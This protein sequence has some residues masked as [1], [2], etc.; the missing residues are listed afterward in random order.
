MPVSSTP[1][2][3]PGGKTI[4]TNFVKLVFARNRLCDGDYAEPFCG[5]AGVAIN[6][7]RQEY[8][9]EAYLNDLSYPIY[10]FWR[11]VLKHTDSLCDRLENTPINV[12]EWYRQRAVFSRGRRAKLADLGFATLFLNRVNRSGILGAGLIGGISQEG[13]WKLDARFNRNG[14]IEKVRTI[15]RYRDRIHLHNVDVRRFIRDVVPTMSKDSLVYLDPPYYVKG[16]SLYDNHFAHADHA[17]L[18]AAI[19]KK[20]HR[21][22]IVS[23]DD[24]PQVRDLYS[25]HRKIYYGLNYTA[26]DRY[27]G[28]EIIVLGNGVTVPKNVSPRAITLKHIESAR[29]AGHKFAR[30]I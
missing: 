20:L 8:I 3:Y 23:Y 12:E 26:A 21:P 24:V 27:E 1:L 18:A 29:L 13:K 9:R 22:W 30:H 19:T 6:L 14:L 4:L 7:L 10:A 15:A 25:A 28:A 16:Q 17:E 11:S 2:R 5:G